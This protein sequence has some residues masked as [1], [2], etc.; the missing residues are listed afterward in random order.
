MTTMKQLVSTMIRSSHHGE[1]IDKAFDPFESTPYLIQMVLL[2]T[3]RSTN[4]LQEYN[5]TECICKQF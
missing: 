4:T 1:K 2:G 3:Y 5:I